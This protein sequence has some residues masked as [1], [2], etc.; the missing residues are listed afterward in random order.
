ML[1]SYLNHVD[2]GKVQVYDIGVLV[3]LCY[4]R[5]FILRLRTPLSSSTSIQIAFVVSFSRCQRL[6][7]V[8]VLYAPSILG[9]N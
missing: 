6:A 4:V 3:V 9:V 2:N 8:C 5:V 7:L 1:R